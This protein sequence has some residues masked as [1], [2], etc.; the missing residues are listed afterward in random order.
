MRYER[1]RDRVRIASSFYA[2]WRYSWL[3][4]ADPAHVAFLKPDSMELAHLAWGQSGVIR[5]R[6]LRVDEAWG[7]LDAQLAIDDVF[8]ID[9]RKLFMLRYV[10]DCERRALRKG[11]AKDAY[12]L[13][14]VATRQRVGER[15]WWMCPS[16]ER[17]CRF[18]YHFRVG[19]SGGDEDALGCRV[20]LGLTYP[21]RARHRC[22]DQDWAQAARGDPAAAERERRRHQRAAKQVDLERRKREALS[23]GLRQRI[24]AMAQ[25]R[26]YGPPWDD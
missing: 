10:Y 19:R 4:P 13:R 7:L 21:S 2:V 9:R 24:S 23:S 20:C 6:A 17:R 26:G 14:M 25:A 12:E 15:C 8:S 16:C 18:L 1:Q 5:Q 22:H 11:V 3:R